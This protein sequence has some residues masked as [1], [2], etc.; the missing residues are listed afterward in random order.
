MTR[1]GPSI[2]ASR[3]KG[4]G[5]MSPRP[6]VAAAAAAPA[7]RQ[8]RSPVTLK[9]VA[10]IVILLVWELFVRAFAPAYVARPT[11]VL[12]A[13]PEVLGSKAFL[14]AAGSTISAVLAGLAIA[15][16]LGTITGLA[17]GRLRVVDWSL[18]YS[19]NFVFV[20]PMVAVLPLM[21]LWFGYSAQARL[22][23]V[24]Y[25]AYL[26][27]TINVADGAKSVPPE[28]LEV[29]RSFRARWHHVLFGITLWSSVPYLLTGIR[30]AAGRALVAAVV[31]EFFIA[32]D[33][34]GYYILYNS[35]VFHHDR[36]L[37]A[38][39]VLSLVA[40]GVELAMN[41]ATR[42]FMDWCYR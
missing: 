22:A 15:I 39:L 31:A 27:I 3:L 37:V 42:R 28:F 36:A 7:P 33:G 32:I 38:V 12:M 21:T 8:G 6:V 2:G 11:G 1:A 4:L 18:R 9:L 34:L 10:G 25:A 13:I 16:V 23:M 35:R 40:V 24:T 41:R 14:L 20:V 19:V 30:L 5:A 29:A 26:S 17:M